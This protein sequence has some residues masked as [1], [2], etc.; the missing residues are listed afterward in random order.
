MPLTEDH[1]F[2]NKKNAP[3]RGR[4]PFWSWMSWKGSVTYPLPYDSTMSGTQ[5][6]ILDP[7][8]IANLDLSPFKTTEKELEI[9]K[10]SLLMLTKFAWL[11]LKIRS[12]DADADVI[13]SEV[14]INQ[15]TGTK[16]FQIPN[17]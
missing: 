1:G 17:K 12:D 14:F 5:P 8:S 6:L 10:S 15:E 9:T 3:Q 11:T 7:C 13:P 2:G 4:L 16:S